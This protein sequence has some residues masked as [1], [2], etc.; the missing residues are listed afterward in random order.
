METPFPRL[1]GALPHIRLG[2][3]DDARRRQR[4]RWHIGSALFAL[5]ALVTVAVAVDR[6]PSAPPAA[7]PKPA[8]APA[9]T[10]LVAW[11]T[12]L[13]RTPY[14]G[15]SC[16]APNS[17]ECDRIGLAVWLKRPA[18]GVSATLLG[19][20]IALDDSQWSGPARN[21]QRKMFAGFLPHAGLATRLGLPPHWEGDPTPFA[22]V[23]L[24]VDYRFGAHVETRLRVPLMAG[25][26]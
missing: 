8:P 5:A 22:R 21:H 11:K 24:R 14:M 18:V 9:A 16:G 25:W 13:T 26:G 20:H 19:R 17:T 4:R 3:I 6:S 23:R 2:V 10:P 15:I 12:V 7:P 1:R